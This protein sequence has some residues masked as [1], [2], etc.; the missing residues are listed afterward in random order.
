M[1]YIKISI[2]SV[3]LKIISKILSLFESSSGVNSKYPSKPIQ[4]VGCRVAWT[5]QDDRETAIMALQL[6]TCSP[7]SISKAIL[8]TFQT[9][10]TQIRLP[11]ERLYEAVVEG[12]Y[13]VQ[14]P[15]IVI[16]STFSDKTPLSYLT[17]QTLSSAHEQAY[18]CYKNPDFHLNFFLCRWCMSAAL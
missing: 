14:S 6:Q 4:P 16:C 2:L 15:C 1:I 3:V 10:I 12:L 8:R 17:T 7:W 13:S 9:P 18:Q 5:K 11:W